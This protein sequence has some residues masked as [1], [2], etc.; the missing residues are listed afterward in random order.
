M[1]T[2]TSPSTHAHCTAALLTPRGRGAVATI[3]VTGPGATAAVAKFFHSP[4]GRRLEAAPHRKVL[5]GR[6]T[7]SQEEL[8]VCRLAEERVE[9]HCHGGSAAAA[10]VMQSLASAGCTPIDWKQWTAEGEPDHLAAQALAALAEART[11][12]TAAIL[13]DQYHGALRDELDPVLNDLAAAQNDS[14]MQR[15]QKLAQYGQIGKRLTTGWRVVLAGAPNVGKSSLI[16]ALVGYRRS[17]VVDRPGTTRDV[18][19]VQTAIDGW[20]VELA[21]TAGLRAAADEIEAAGVARARAATL[22]ADVVVLVTEFG[23]AARESE[24]LP[25]LADQQR[26]LRVVNK[27]DLA[28]P[29]TAS[30]LNGISTSALNGAGID[31]LIAAISAAI[32]PAAPPPGAA[33]PFSQ[34]QLS[35][36]SSALAALKTGDGELA[37]VRIR[38]VLDR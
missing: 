25:P 11:L 26:I 35:A 18:V 6:W 7:S 19:A 31:K 23:A 32:V 20:P 17:I 21:D 15:L 2:K 36:I 1:P 34:P 27:S 33:V 3:A 28:P 30:S 8:V 38:E 13:L 16:N 22:Q 37:A 5:F 14:A 24:F 4:S 10:A 9:I 29:E 12:R